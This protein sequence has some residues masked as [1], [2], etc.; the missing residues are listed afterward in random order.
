ME[1]D[2]LVAPGQIAGMTVPTMPP[3]LKSFVKR[4]NRRKVQWW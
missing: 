1:W 4:G 2:S 3:S